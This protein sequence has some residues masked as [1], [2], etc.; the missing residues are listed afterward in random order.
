MIPRKFTSRCLALLAC[1]ISVH[2]AVAGQPTIGSD[3]CSALAAIV[4]S[5]VLDSGDRGSRGPDSPTLFAGLGTVAVCDTATRSVT[6]AFTAALRQQNIYVSWGYRSGVSGDYCLSHFLSQCYPDGD[7]RLPPLG[8]GDAWYVASRWYA[9][10]DAMQQVM[11]VVS[12]N[13][14]ARFDRLQLSQ[15]MRRA[16]AA[17]EIRVP[18]PLDVER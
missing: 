9:I 2:A 17:T 11:R 7:P 1:L 12:G 3:G 15:S 8:A 16:I 10:S 5:A 13:D 4:Y 14:S 18:V 6:R